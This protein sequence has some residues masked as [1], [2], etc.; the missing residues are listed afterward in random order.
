MVRG[1]LSERVGLSYSIMLNSIKK[2][3]REF[4][5]DHVVLALEGD[6]WRKA[7]FDP[8]KRNRLVAAAKKTVSER[9]EDMVF[10]EAFEEL[11]EFFRS[12]TNVTVLQNPILEGDDLVAAWTQQHPNDNHVV[13]SS[14]T[15]FIQLVSPNV[16]LYCGMKDITYKD[17][18]IY[19]SKGRKLQ[20]IITSN[21]K[22]KTSKPLSPGE[23]S[24]EDERWKEWYSFLKTVRGDPG[25]NVFSAFPGARV[26][27]TKNKVGIREA[28]EDSE[29]RGYNWNNFMLQHWTDVEGEET[30]VLKAYKRN[31]ELIDL[32]AQPEPIKE[33]CKET[34][35]EAVAR[36]PVRNVGLYFMKL[37]GKHDMPR[38]TNEATEFGRMLGRKYHED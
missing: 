34:I 2:M 12:K 8:Y 5:G 13:I 19:D 1:D 18:G 3:Y 21:A 27:G 29:A 15:D 23:E 33:V 35:S 36:E 25:D 38:L 11:S 28:F 32:T 7:V 14:D 9:E 17:D 16:N 24:H 4:K 26:K 37:C 30:T 31:V 10:K 6:S 20:F 22:I